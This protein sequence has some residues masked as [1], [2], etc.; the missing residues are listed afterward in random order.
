MALELEFLASDVLESMES[1]EKIKFILRKIKENKILVIDSQLSSFEESKLIEETMKNID[2]KFTG[3]EIST[4]SQ[5][6]VSGLR[7][8][9]IRIL[10]GKKGGLTV[11][12]PSKIV[13]KIKKDPRKI[14][15]F[16]EFSERNKKKRGKKK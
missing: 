8:K 13:K 5:S 12:G 1:E 7:E 2:N 16:A 9:L 11:I 4:L 6:N 15:L 3:I 14:L 10:G